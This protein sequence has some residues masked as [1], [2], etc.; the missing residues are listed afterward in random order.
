MTNTD[1]V[2]VLT[3]DVTYSFNQKNI[4][5]E[6]DLGLMLPDPFYDIHVDDDQST[7]NYGFLQGK[8]P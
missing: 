4:A 6:F 8:L 5:A 2:L 3:C 1:I 7:K